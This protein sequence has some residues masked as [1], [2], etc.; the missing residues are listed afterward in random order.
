MSEAGETPVM[1]L[2]VATEMC[3]ANSQ[4]HVTQAANPLQDNETT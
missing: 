2:A 3:N 4:I 1:L